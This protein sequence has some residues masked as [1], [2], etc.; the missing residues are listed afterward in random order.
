MLVVIVLDK[1]VVVIGK[2]MG[3]LEQVLSCLL[4]NFTEKCLLRSSTY[5]IPP[6]SMDGVPSETFSTF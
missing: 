1:Q 4:Y 2:V 6:V 3:K 5:M